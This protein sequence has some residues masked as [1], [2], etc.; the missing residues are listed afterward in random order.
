MEYQIEFLKEIDYIKV[1]RFINIEWKKDH[2]LS[3]S[4]DLFDWQYLN[5][6]KTYN[7]VVLKNKNEICGVLGFIPS[8]RYDK[9]LFKENVLWL[10]LWKISNKIK[11]KGIGLKM[12]AFLQKNVNHIGIGVNGINKDH[13][14]MYRA[15]GYKSDN[16]NHYYS[17][18]K[19]CDLKIISSPK[20]YNHPYPNPIGS[21]WILLN[22][23]VIKN[24]KEIYSYK[25]LSHSPIKKTAYYFLNRYIKHPFYDYQVYIIPS[26]DQK[27][28]AL[29]S[30]R[31]DKIDKSKVLRIV[32]FYGNIEILNYAG[33]GLEKIINKSSIEYV[34]FFSYGIPDEIMTNF[35]FRIVDYQQNI[36]VPNYFEP[37]VN[38]N[39]KVLFA[40]KNI[41]KSKNQ[42]II[43]KG[44][45]DQD[46]PN[47][48]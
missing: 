6:N 25:I 14:S 43:C 48:F 12:L 27:E 26:I 30:I 10:A 19:N 33:Y 18:N 42:F 9:N 32:D 2:I 29:I 11:I 13:P 40:F 36:I 45:G 41:I 16:L 17:V 39:F 15:L 5:K 24:F 21:N 23:N 22:E 7:F 8:S 4:K 37:F 3:K 47:S 1:S 46:R 44:D 34:D 28:A 38:K 31:I 35:G 20:D